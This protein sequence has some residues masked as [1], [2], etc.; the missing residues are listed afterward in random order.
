MAEESSSNTPTALDSVLEKVNK[1][2]LWVASSVIGIIAT[3]GDEL[4]DRSFWGLIGIA[5]AYG[6]YRTVVKAAEAY[7]DAAR[8]RAE[9]AKAEAD[10]KTEA[11]RYRGERDA[12]RAEITPVRK[13]LA[14]NAPLLG[15]FN[16]WL[17]KES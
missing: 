10:A 4:S 16:A 5:V 13:W 12:L 1:S 2:E 17:Q 8:A 3:R 7:R 9:A 11:G 14:D 15:Q 6:G